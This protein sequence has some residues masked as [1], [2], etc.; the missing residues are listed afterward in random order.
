MASTD[1]LDLPTLR[2]LV[3][4][5]DGSTSLVAEMTDLFREDSPRR[6]QEIRAALQAGA[7]EAASRTAHALKGG[8]GAI[9]AKAL[10]AQAAALEALAHDPAATVPETVLEQLEHTFQATLQALEDYIHTGESQ[11][12]QG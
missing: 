8:S 7:R 10:R 9:G 12:G 2:N 5:D 6:I 3:D 1:L 4:L 11:P